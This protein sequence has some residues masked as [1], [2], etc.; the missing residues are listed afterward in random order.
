M[1]GVICSASSRALKAANFFHEGILFGLADVLVVRGRGPAFVS[2]I[3][4]LFLSG[5][6]PSAFLE[7]LS[8]SFGH[9]VA[10]AR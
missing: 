1:S 9:L 2:L 6:L 5:P 8:A 10:T 4:L 3:G 7:A